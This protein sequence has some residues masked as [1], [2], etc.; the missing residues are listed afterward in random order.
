MEHVRYGNM[1]LHAGFGFAPRVSVFAQAD[2]RAVFVANAAGSQISD[3][4]N[5]GFGDAFLGL[6]WLLYRSRST[7]RVYPSEWSPSTWMVLAEGTWLFPMY[8]KAKSGKPP[9]GNQSNDF[10][11]MGRLVW[12]ANEWLALA[13]NAG[14]TYRT[15]GYSAA[16]P[17]G[18]RAD[19]SFLRTS[20]FRTWIDFQAYERTVTDG[21]VLNPRQP[22][23]IPGGSLLF[24]SDSPTLRSATIG[25][26][27]LIGKEWELATGALFT[28]TGVNAAKGF[29]G[30]LGLAWRPY[31]VPEIDYEQ[32]RR[33]QLQRLEKEP[34]SYRRKAVMRYGLKATVLKVSHQGNFFR[35]GYGATDGIKKGDM[36]QVFAP[37]D[38]SGETRKPLAFARVQVARPEDSFLRVEERYD[39]EFRLQSGQEAHRVILE[40]E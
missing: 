12:Y 17:W 4:E 19:L 9:L 27:Y 10:T 31:Q 29:G 6:R 14:Y 32:F 21:I 2:L 7:D 39:P 33:E 20:R 3:T 26:A 16:V 18:L 36:F 24:K 13:A 23:A 40:E 15:A 8:D 5:Y 34:R 30:A 22:D 37:D 38:L 35:I 25:L 1:R 11:A 28:A